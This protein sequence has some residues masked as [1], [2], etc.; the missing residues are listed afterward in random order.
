MNL[1]PIQIPDREPFPRYAGCIDTVRLMQIFDDS[2]RLAL[3]SKVPDTACHRRDLAI[4]VYHQLRVLNAHQPVHDTIVTML[5]AFPVRVRINEA[6]GLVSKAEKLKTPRRK[7]DLLQQALG[8][9]GSLSGSGPMDAERDQL[10]KSI[11]AALA[12]IEVH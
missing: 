4:E 2:V 7:A 10:A 9:I 5:T 1:P 6:K 8:V 3:S 11:S 12:T